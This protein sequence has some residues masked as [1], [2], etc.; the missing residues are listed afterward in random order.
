MGPWPHVAALTHALLLWGGRGDKAELS[1]GLCHAS[2]FTE[3]E[4]AEDKQKPPRS[5]LGA[6]A[7]RPGQVAQP[8]VGV[9]ERRDW[10]QRGGRRGTQQGPGALAPGC[11]EGMAGTACTLHRAGRRPTFPGA[12]PRPSLGF[13]PLGSGRPP[14][15][16][17]LGGACSCLASPCSLHCFDLGAG[18][19]PSPGAVTSCRCAQARD[20]ADTSA[21]CCLDPL[22]TV[23][24]EEYTGS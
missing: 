15:P 20:S 8:R 3:P 1:P 16:H 11:E 23:G 18:V 19:G 17:R 9:M 6:A 2:R 7:M 12:G 21:P 13:V 10:A 14:C 24:S 4:G 5:P 22:R